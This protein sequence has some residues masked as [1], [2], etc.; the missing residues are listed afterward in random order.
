[1]EDTKYELKLSTKSRPLA[2]P[3]L[4]RDEEPSDEA[5]DQMNEWI[6]GQKDLSKYTSLPS[7]KAILAALHG[8]R[9]SDGRNK[10]LPSGTTKDDFKDDDDI[11]DAD[12]TEGDGD[13]DMPDGF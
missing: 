1:M 12:F 2:G 5:V 8:E 7:D 9:P 13:D 4:G 6:T 11:V 10:Q 3:R